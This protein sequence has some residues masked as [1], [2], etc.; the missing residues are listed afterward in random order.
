[1]AVK[2]SRYIKREVER[3]LWAKAAGRCQ[4][5][6][7]NRPLYKSPV[8]QEHVNISEKA[9]I[10]SFSENG[11][12]GW[13]PFITNRAQI[14]D[15]SNLMLVCHD[16][17]TK[18]DQDKKEREAPNAFTSFSNDFNIFCCCLSPSFFMVIHIFYTRFY[19]WNNF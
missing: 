16:C 10:Y 15:I 18:I 8:T 2:V 3:V 13:G 9:H 6:G 11:P 1:M 7:C 19:T 4:F 14:N 12:R 17:H 5:N